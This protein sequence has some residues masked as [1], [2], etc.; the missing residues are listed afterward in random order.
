MID[1]SL[2]LAFVLV[3]IVII[4]IR[5]YQNE[6]PRKKEFEKELEKLR[7]EEND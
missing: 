4:T 1:I 6:D 2:I 5:I 7:G 3:C